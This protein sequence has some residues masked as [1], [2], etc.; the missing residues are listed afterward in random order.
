MSR[1]GNWRAGLVTLRTTSRL[2]SSTWKRSWHS[3]VAQ[4]AWIYEKLWAW[5]DNQ[6]A[7]EDVFSLDTM[8]DNIMLYWLSEAGASAARMYWESF[9]DLPFVPV[10]VPSGISIFPVEAHNASKRWCEGRFRNL[11]HYNVLPK[12]G[13]F[14]AFEQPATFVDEVRAAFRSVR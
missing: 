13:H 1:T 14:A 7:P 6:G 4:A 12:G 10:K 2:P 3:P 9:R 11:V 8:L 5:T